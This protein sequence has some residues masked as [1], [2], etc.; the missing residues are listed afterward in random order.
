MSEQPV[1]TPAEGSF[2]ADLRGVHYDF[3]KARVP[4]W[5]NQGLLQ[6]QEE[7]ANHEMELPSGYLTAT[8]QEK[9]ALAESHTRYHAV[10]PSVR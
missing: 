3:L 8:A 10:L 5:F 9:T 1:T 2:T 4:A 7:L 6:R